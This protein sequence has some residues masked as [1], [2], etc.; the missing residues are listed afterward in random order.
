MKLNLPKVFLAIVIAEAMATF[1]QENFNITLNHTDFSIPL[2]VGPFK[3]NALIATAADLSWFPYIDC[4]TCQE[5]HLLD[6]N[7]SRT[8]HLESPLGL[9][10]TFGPG[11]I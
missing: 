11:S 8:Y 5:M 9:N 7:E 1:S 4:T 2:R 6:F 3:T 10:K